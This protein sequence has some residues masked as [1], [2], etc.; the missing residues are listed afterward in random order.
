MSSILPQKSQNTNKPM[1]GLP[2]SVREALLGADLGDS[3]LLLDA[4]IRCRYKTG[5][6]FTRKQLLDS[7]RE[8]GLKVPD[9]VI[10]RGLDEKVFVV[11]KILALGTKRRGRPTLAYHMPAIADL[12][13]TWC[14]GV[15]TASDRLCETDFVS[16]KAYRIALHRE[17]IN[18]DPGDYSRAFLGRRLGVSEA[19]TRNYDKLAGITVTE[20]KKEHLIGEDWR[21]V[22]DFKP[23]RAIY[24]WLKI[25]VD[26]GLQFCCKFSAETVRLWKDRAK[27]YVVVQLTNSYSCGGA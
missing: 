27:I 22:F 12:V 2:N 10:Q 14:W 9:G 25:V 8:N 19:T 6:I 1:T 17:F 23:G 20:R 21:S 26:D 7:L 24:R 15:D 3:A 11:G 5:K 18:R 13:R 16:L 4:M